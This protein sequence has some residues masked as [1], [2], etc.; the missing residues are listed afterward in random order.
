[1]PVT[2]ISGSSSVVSRVPGAP[3]RVTP[4][5][6]LRRSKTIAVTP[7]A[8]RGVMRIADADAGHVGDEVVRRA[9]ALARD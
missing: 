6:T 7:L 8:M 2:V 3:P 5:A 1:M 4:E 9:Q